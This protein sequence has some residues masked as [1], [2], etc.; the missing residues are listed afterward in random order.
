MK[1]VY[2]GIFIFLFLF[3]FTY[4]L[5]PVTLNHPSGAV[6]SIDN[7]KDFYKQDAKVDLKITC[8][9]GNQ[10]YCDA[11]TNCTININYPDSILLLA[12]GSMTRQG[13]YFNYTISS[14]LLNQTGLYQY[15]LN[16]QDPDYGA[17]AVGSF[18]V[19]VTGKEK[20]TTTEGIIYMIVVF[21][22]TLIFFLAMWGIVRIKGGNIIDGDGNIINVNNLKYLKIFLGGIAYVMLIVLAYFGM[23]IS[24]G[25]VSFNLATGIFQWMFEILMYAFTP[26]AVLL[27]I[28]ITFKFIKDIN[29]KKTL[30]I[31]GEYH[32]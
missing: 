13:S 3:S 32:A 20:P 9:D 24:Y 15:S 8:Y 7:L 29:I 27:F 17:V 5:Q 28:F 10:S 14:G 18:E 6:Q 16:C 1:K 2:I 25:F 23:N 22:C 11:S 26:F 4:A 21:I 31:G 19:S 12:N 30:R